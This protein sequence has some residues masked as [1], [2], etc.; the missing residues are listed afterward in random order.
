MYYIKEQF[1]ILRISVFDI[2]P[3]MSPQPGI[4]LEEKENSSKT[5]N[6]KSATPKHSSNGSAKKKLT[7]KSNSKKMSANP[8]GMMDLSKWLVKKESTSAP[9]KGFG[10]SS[11]NESS[12]PEIVSS[13]KSNEE[14]GEKSKNEA[15]MYIQNSSSESE[16]QELDSKKRKVAPEIKEDDKIKE[17]EL[18]LS[19]RKKRNAAKRRRIMVLDSDDDSDPS[20]DVNEDARKQDS[21]SD[22]EIEKEDDTGKSCT[23]AMS[24]ATSSDASDLSPS[25]EDDDDD[26]EESLAAIKKKVASK[27]V[28]KT[29]WGSLTPFNGKVAKNAAKKPTKSPRAS[30]AS[31]KASSGAG[32]TNLTPATKGGVPRSYNDECANL[33]TISEPQAMFDD[34][35][36]KLPEIKKLHKHLNGRSLRVATMC[37][38]T[39]SPILAL[40]MIALAAK[41]QYDIDINI[42]HVFSCEIE[43]FK[44]A[45]IER[46]FHPPILFRDIRELGNQRAMTAYGSMTKVPGE[47]DILIAGTSCVDYSNLN[48]KQKTI[49]QKGESGQTFRGMLQWIKKFQ[50]PLVIIENVSGAPWDT[51]VKIF[52]E[53]LNYHADFLR[54]DTKAY[55]IP[56]TR[57]RGYLVGVL[58]GSGVK[59]SAFLKEWKEKI[60]ELRRPASAVLD[61]FMFP[62]DDPRV[63]KGR[64]R[65]ADE[66]ERSGRVDWARCESRHLFARVEEELGDKRPLTGW[67]D[68]GNTTMP[69]FAW[70]EWCNGQ[71]HRVQDL[72]DI[73][74]LRLAKHG[75]DCTYKTMIWNLSQNVD[76][77]TMGKLGLSQCLTPTGEPY[78]INRGGPLVG[79][80]L[81]LLQ[82]IPADDLLL[83]RETEKQLRDLAGNAMS[84]T[85]VGA[86]SISALVLAFNALRKGDDSSKNEGKQSKSFVRAP[87]TIHDNKNESAVSL[88]YDLGEYENKPLPLEE[89]S[90]QNNLDKSDMSLRQLLKEAFSSSRLCMS[91]SQF[92]CVENILIC[93]LCGH[94]SSRICARPPR[95]FEEH[96]FVKYSRTRLNPK[97]FERKLL[98]YLPM[99]IQ[100]CNLNL[101]NDTAM[102]DGC[103]LNK[104]EFEKWVETFNNLAVA[105]MFFS[106]ISRAYHKWSVRF[107]S[108]HGYLE[109]IIGYKDEAPTWRL[110]ANLPPE[111]G[112]LRESMENHLATM[113]VDISNI[114]LNSLLEGSWSVI[115]PAIRKVNVTFN[116]QGKKVESWEAKLGLKGQFDNDLRYSSF[117]VETS[118]TTLGINGSY[119]LLPR[120]GAAC[121]SLHKH[122][123]NQNLFFYLE[124]ERC[125]LSKDDKFVISNTKERLQYGEKRIGKIITFPGGWRPECVDKEQI[126]QG[127]IWGQKA[128]KKCKLTAIANDSKCNLKVIDSKGFSVMLDHTKLD[129]WN[130]APV[131]VSCSAPLQFSKTNNNLWSR[132]ENKV[133][134]D[135]NLQKSKSVMENLAWIVKKLSLPEGITEWHSLMRN[136]K[137]SPRGFHS[138]KCSPKLPYVRWM[139]IQKGNSVQYVPK[140]DVQ[141]AGQFERALKE[142]P[143]AWNMQLMK[144]MS[145]DTVFLQIGLNPISL[146]HRARGMLVS[147]DDEEEGNEQDE[148]NEEPWEFSFRV[149]DHI[150]LEKNPT[151]PKLT[152]CSNKE[153]KESKQPPNFK[154]YPLRVEQLRSLN[155]MVEQES[156]NA[157]PFIEEEVCESIL[158]GGLGWRAEGKVERKKLVQGGIV[159]DQVGYGKTAITLGLIDMTTN[160][161]PDARTDLFS[162]NAT[163]VV[164]PSHLTGQ[165]PNEIGK[166]L[167][168]SKNTIVI[169]DMNSFNNLTIKEVEDA[170]IVVVNFTVLS[171]DKYHE[172]LARLAGANAGSLPAGKKGG[173]HFNAV[174]GE[175][176]RGIKKRAKELR[177]NSGKNILNNIDQEARTHIEEEEQARRTGQGV[178]LDGKKAVYKQLDEDDIRAMDEDKNDCENKALKKSKTYTVPKGVDRDPWALSTLKDDYKRMKCPPLEIFHWKR[179][180]IDEFHY[181]AEKADRARVYTLVLGLKSTF[182]WCL[183]GTPPHANFNDIKGLANLLGVH[184]GIDEVLP[185]T[186]TG[187]RGAG[188]RDAS[189]R[190]KTA[191]EKFAGLLEMRSVYWH[192]RRHLHAQKF[193]DKFVR[194][195]IAEIDEIPYEEHEV[196]IELPPAERAIYLEL[197]THLKSLEMNKQKAV[198]CKKNSKGDRDKRMQQVNISL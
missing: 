19:G 167:G 41:A 186:K 7:P 157:K 103:P 58:K 89:Y 140:E 101:P 110:F 122:S 48:T 174:Y 75:L 33:N 153:D 49:T 95:K 164:V 30:M 135:I 11:A 2:V 175:C 27:A 24:E 128:L 171:S 56:H 187:G 120:C 1:L 67:S 189:N 42:E 162:V 173:R 13:S 147:N 10:L 182:R 62:N 155:W 77:D 114:N 90:Q 45:Y 197:E 108:S 121:G 190:E 39:E 132:M 26:E 168:K 172:R 163:L 52:E 23:E 59:G 161:C 60:Q 127:T 195:N 87:I 83:T 22:F 72:M 191:C 148:V 159:A 125:T 150:D 99:R 106:G 194:Q 154:R 123:K 55:Y 54:M 44:Q 98:H 38:G 57:Q 97:Q 40:D 180:V 149:I 176:L 35:V 79:E 25:S 192:E 92:E 151:F 96:S 3:I 193:L 152:L 107:V 102:P 12:E 113:D 105:P 185:G 18:N 124:A 158:G 165:W 117:K 9:K 116:G 20:E 15:D 34:M 178:R 144:E 31:K 111:A 138:E 17:N 143:G 51:K 131:V 177:E 61:A 71:V 181:L 179:V 21:D 66:E 70:N 141:E 68:S 160:N 47:C 36:S 166:F 78:V 29:G 84:T 146:V 5:S 73:N 88:T 137:T 14:I 115:Y 145:K 91:E 196:Y 85:V 119:N 53:E 136:P 134:H 37:S 6:A 170:D 94:T 86:C 183:S 139:A 129:S 198:K 8:K 100:F 16:V 130:R 32:T 156:P 64:Q 112:P 133:W 4:C 65:L 118:D 93:T 80:E 74:T 126:I 142:R 50:P 28:T 46:N 109:L 82:G 169:K 81:L 188:L 184:L 76:R 69:S 63:L 43:P 104:K